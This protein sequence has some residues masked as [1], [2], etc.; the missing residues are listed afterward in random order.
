MP[1]SLIVVMIVTATFVESGTP[2]TETWLRRETTQEVCRAM[3]GLSGTAPNGN[4]I[5]VTCRPLE[6][7]DQEPVP[8]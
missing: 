3:Q 5:T 8:K 1:A 4:A 6:I 7:A 2:V